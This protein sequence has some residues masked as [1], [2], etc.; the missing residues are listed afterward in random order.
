MSVKAATRLSI[1]PLTGALLFPR[2]HLPLHIFEPRYCAMVAES[3]ARDRRI[4]MIQPSGVTAPSGHSA[5]PLF[6][7]GCV[8]RI[9]EVEALD[10]GR[11]N[12]VLEG[13]SRFVMLRELTVET[14]FRQVEAELITEPEDAILEMVERAQLERESRRFADAQGYAV[15]WEAVSRLDDEALVNGIAQVAPF[16][17]AAK[18]ALLEAKTLSERAELIIQLMQFFGRYDGESRVTLQ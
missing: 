3:L 5:P 7:M 8:G 4:G 17:G 2:M 6:N 14:P 10:E 1:F 12:L 11:Y 9:A 13:L 18:Q 16:D 15:D